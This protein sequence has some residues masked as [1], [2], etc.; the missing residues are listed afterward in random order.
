MTTVTDTDLQKR[1]TTEERDAM[2]DA[3]ADALLMG[4]ADEADRILVQ[5]PV[6][7]R[8]AKNIRD[9]M[10]TEYL[11][12]HFNITEANRVFGEGWVD[13]KEPK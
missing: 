7:A 3:Y 2:L 12:E 5:I 10:G 9:V 13:G 8:W 11:K 6:N 1:Y 4:D